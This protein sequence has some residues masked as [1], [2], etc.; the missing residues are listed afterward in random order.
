MG[1]SGKKTKTVVLI[2]GAWMTPISWEGFKTYFEKQGFNVIT[3]TWPL[4]DKSIEELRAHPDDHFGALSFKEIVDH[5]EKVI[6]ALPEPPLLV[7]HSMGGLVVQL[8]LDRGVGA[9]GICID[10]APIAGVIPDLRSLT[11]ALPGLLRL[12]G[13]RKPY[14]LSKEAF[15]KNFANTTPAVQRDVDYKRLVVPAPGKIFFQAATGIGTRVDAKH[16][17]QPLLFIAGESDRTAAPAMVKANYRKQKKSPSRTDL[18]SFAGVSHYLIAEP[19]WEKVADA[20]VKW[21]QEVM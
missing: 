12:A 21:A 2:H 20:S 7:G 19:G 4:M 6:R 9:A 1:T 13:W 11:S 18:K 10:P 8:L 5:L 15:D 3:P 16:R 14:I 17:K